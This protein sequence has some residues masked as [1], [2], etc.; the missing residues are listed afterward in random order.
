MAC[1]ASGIGDVLS[2]MMKDTGMPIVLPPLLLLRYSVSHK[3]RQIAALTT[4]AALIA[5]TV[6]AAT[7]LS[8]FDLCFIVIAIASG[9]T[10]LS[11]RQ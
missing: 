3:A 11:P 9:A 7:D 5:P 2:E 4:T 1:C 8:Q 10:V 6:A